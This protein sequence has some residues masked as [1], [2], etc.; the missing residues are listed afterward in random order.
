MTLQDV[1]TA[2][3]VAALLSVLA[4]IAV[5]ARVPWWRSSLGRALM[6]GALAV[7]LISIVGVIRR[8]DNRFNDGSHADWLSIGS[9]IAYLM[10]ALVWL[11]KAKVVREEERPPIRGDK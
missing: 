10:I 6:T 8:F 4:F 3:N 9:S 1:L 2:A 7:G 11:Y 5:Y